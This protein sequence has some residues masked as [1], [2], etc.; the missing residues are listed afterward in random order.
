MLIR[1][2]TMSLVQPKLTEEMKSAFIPAPT[3][4][5][6]R[7]VPMPVLG[8][9]SYDAGFINKADPSFYSPP[10]QGEQ[11]PTMPVD[12]TSPITM[13]ATV[14]PRTA[15]SGTV[16]SMPTIQNNIP[17]VQ[18][19]PA[20]Q[21]TQQTVAERTVA[22]ATIMNIP[23]PNDQVAAPPPPG[24]FT[25]LNQP[26]AGAANQTIE[27]MVTGKITDPF[28]AKQREDRARQE[29][30][31]RASN[32][33][34]ISSAGFSGTGIGQ[35][36]G[37]A[38]DNQIQKNR[39]DSEVGIE[40]IRNENRVAGVN[41]ATTV[42][43]AQQQ[44]SRNAL[45]DALDFGS[46]ADVIAAYKQTYGKDLDPA[47]VEEFRGSQRELRA[48]TVE[49]GEIKLK[50]LKSTKAGKD[51]ATYVQGNLDSTIE[52][53]Q[54]LRNYAQG[55]W[56]SSG[57]TG[58]VPAD[59]ANARIKAVNDPRLTN[60]YV[61][62][63]REL[64]IAV[65]NGAL[66]R[67]VADLIQEFSTQGLLTRDP[68]TGKA[69]LNL[70]MFNQMYGGEGGGVVINNNNN[71]TVPGN[72]S[73]P[74]KDGLGSEVD[75][76]YVGSDGK[77]YRNTGEGESEVVRS[78]DISFEDI[79]QFNLGTDS[80][81]YKTLLRNTDPL[82]LDYKSKTLTDEWG[83]GSPEVGQ[84]VKFNVGGKEILG[85]VKKK[86]TQDVALGF[87]NAYMEFEDLDGNKYYAGGTYKDGTVRAGTGDTR[88]RSAISEYTPI[89]QINEVLRNP[90]PG[91]V[92]EA[93]L[94][95][96]PLGG[97]VAAVKAIHKW[98]S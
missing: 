2:P 60:Q 24:I 19:S 82:D 67:E 29:A 54:S 41:L 66:P 83:E 31:A 59:W 96:T 21:N 56:E 65:E 63:R 74:P 58:P 72:N 43:Q 50:D 97:T 10:P 13:Q 11:P 1:R 53:D 80:A 52:N 18:N 57:N 42:G 71:N 86:G 93:V 15:Q 37:A 14:D 30:N 69:T 64:D 17:A 81:G 88:S 33:N 77:T 62:T 91:N 12:G 89:G 68:K 55:L 48:Q 40:Q 75:D 38:Q 25:G 95:V 47:A 98:L 9:N 87:D 20:V 85:T 46:N 76:L 73:L 78:S 6:P 27:D 16:M 79:K 28:A 8:G 3:W 5:P 90:T 22:P 4:T 7:V 36:L 23:N 61:A 49:A 84:T 94:S 34:R 45:S 92:V 51:F 39:F 44:N 35:Q 32:A 70:D 26:V